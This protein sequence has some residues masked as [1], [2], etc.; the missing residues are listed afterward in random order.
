MTA[1]L[2]HAYVIMMTIN[3]A[4]TCACDKNIAE[5]ISTMNYQDQQHQERPWETHVL[6]KDLLSKSNGNQDVILGWE[7]LWNLSD[8]AASKSLFGPANANE[9]TFPP[10]NAH[11]IKDYE[12]KYL[13]PKNTVLLPKKFFSQNKHSQKLMAYVAIDSFRSDSRD[14]SKEQPQDSKVNQLN[15]LF[16]CLRLI[17]RDKAVAL[18][19]TE[20]I[21]QGQH[22]KI[23]H[24]GQRCN[25]LKDFKKAWKENPSK[26]MCESIYKLYYGSSWRTGMKGCLYH[27]MVFDMLK[28]LGLWHAVR[29][30]GKH[31]RSSCYHI[32]AEVMRDNFRNS[33]MKAGKNTH[34]VSI[35]LSEKNKTDIIQMSLNVKGWNE[36]K[37]KNFL[38][39][40]SL[41]NFFA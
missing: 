12:L 2:S 27:R 23:Y 20:L 8:T 29:R 33:L 18:I 39:I 36:D 30:G 35:Q 11:K 15:A 10:D 25:S 24:Q 34:G 7:Y 32:L 28:V 41:V 4:C 3:D 26:E 9:A 22:M 37:H 14:S 19:N 38:V 1:T 6:Y 31:E 5:D 40:T 17:M 13:Q 21:K 16:G